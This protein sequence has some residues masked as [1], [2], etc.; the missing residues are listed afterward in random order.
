M[1]ATAEDT[2]YIRDRQQKKSRGLKPGQQPGPRRSIC[3]TVDSRSNEIAS[4]E[5]LLVKN[6]S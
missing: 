3:G 4:N 2:D 1:E 5:F 6:K